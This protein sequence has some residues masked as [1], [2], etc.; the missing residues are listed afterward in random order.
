MTVCTKNNFKK[1]QD[2]REVV[3]IK[4]K[5]CYNILTHGKYKCKIEPIFGKEI[6]LIPDQHVNIPYIYVMIKICNMLMY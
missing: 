4:I 6:L 1:I 5:E 2:C 3:Q